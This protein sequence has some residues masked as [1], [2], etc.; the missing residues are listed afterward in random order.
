MRSVS[1]F[2][3][4]GEEANVSLNRSCTRSVAPSERPRRALQYRSQS[5]ARK[6]ACG[7]FARAPR[8]LISTSSGTLD[9][10][11]RRERSK[12]NGRPGKISRTVTA[13]HRRPAAGNTQSVR[14]RRSLIVSAGFTLPAPTRP[15][16]PSC[17]DSGDISRLRAPL[18]FPE[19]LWEAR[20]ATG[21]TFLA[22]TTY[23]HNLTNTIWARWVNS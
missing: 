5:H 16:C 22:M 9:C 6:C 13:S 12:Q 10:G 23:L 2:R 11:G 14:S 1:Q 4:R 7:R 3:L 19:A 17:S 15:R 20:K 8:F 21:Y 18:A